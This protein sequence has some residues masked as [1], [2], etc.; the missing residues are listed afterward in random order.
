MSSELKLPSTRYALKV[1]RAE[2]EKSL[3]ELTESYVNTADEFNIDIARLSSELPTL[4]SNIG[5][6]VEKALSSKEVRLDYY[7]KGPLILVTKNNSERKPS[8]LLAKQVKEEVKA[9]LSDRFGVQFDI[10]TKL[11]PHS[12][13]ELLHKVHEL[14]NIRLDRLYS[15]APLMMDDFM[16]NPSK[17]I[18]R[19]DEID[20]DSLD[21]I[22]M[23]LPY[24]ITLKEY[25]VSP[26]EDRLDLKAQYLEV[27]EVLEGSYFN[28]ADASL[29][30]HAA[31]SDQ[32]I[33]MA[34]NLITSLK[35]NCQASHDFHLR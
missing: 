3:A 7:T 13:D 15:A 29:E 23:I 20:K 22:N 21:V 33:N 27:A 2:L 26:G 6:R 25:D 1:I 31:R 9:F 4:L 11:Y 30:Y 24:Y 18:D 14:M 34:M 19:L 35:T 12:H 8:C 16:K 5:S 10:E 28:Q 17:Y 32:E